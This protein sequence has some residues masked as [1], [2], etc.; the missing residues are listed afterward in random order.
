[1][2]CRT[3]EIIELPV[4]GCA[5]RGLGST[6]A[7]STAR[8]PQSAQSPEFTH[9][10]DTCIGLYPD[11]ARSRNGL[12]FALANALQALGLPSELVPGNAHSSPPVNSAA[13]RLHSAFQ[14]AQAS[15]VYICPL[16][17]VD[18]LPEL[19]FGSARIAKLTAAELKDLVDTD[20]LRR[21]NAD[22]KFDA[23]SFAKFTWL[24][25]QETVRFDREPGIRA[26]P[27]LFERL[28]TDW[29]RIEPHRQRVPTAVENALFFILLAP[30]ED[31][32]KW[33]D[34]EWRGFQVP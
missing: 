2:H 29:A 31:W 25:V 32:V 12:S 13:A 20:R 10:L 14:R 5:H 34:D 33:P 7:Y 8:A 19:K 9:L 18:E 3:P 22:W 4:P 28:D 15:R 26:I 24:V 17:T 27:L 6:L 1:L 30:W 23:D 11:K 21:I 16:D